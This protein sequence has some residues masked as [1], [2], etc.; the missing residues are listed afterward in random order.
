MLIAFSTL[1]CPEWTL[2]RVAGA[3][4]AMGFSGV[5]LRTF[6]GASAELA[7]DPALTDPA[8][9]RALF[10][11]AGV[12]IA[13]LATGIRFDTPAPLPILERGTREYER[14]VRETRWA[15]DLARNLGCPLVRVFGFEVPSGRGR[16][17][18]LARIVDRLRIACDHA[19]NRGAS[20][21]LENAG[22]FR[23]AAD[24]AGL[25]DRVE[26]PLLGASYSLAVGVR[27]GD[28]PA[29]A[30]SALGSMLVAARVRDMRG[31]RMVPVGSGE[32]P[33]A[34]FVAA[35]ARAGF[36]GP[37]VVEWDRAFVEGL[38]D[39]ENVLPPA[40]AAIARWSLPTSPPRAP[41][42]ARH[43]RG[44]TA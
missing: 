24:L 5:E 43:P 42:S 35:I 3:A 22:S 6:G 26:S 23:S 8:K 34:E 32:V 25:I 38:A 18:A 14:P 36:E 13:S 12:R 40:A 31:T 11:R 1:A 15:I 2:D 27:A 20:L 17:R 37:V 19:R 29:L 10:D 16:T 28:H 7:C 9:T 44:V 41:G 30:V 21:A 4:G 39:P 33:C